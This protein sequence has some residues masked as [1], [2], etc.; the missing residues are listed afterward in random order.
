[1]RIIWSDEAIESVDN[2]ADYI[3]DNFGVN[4]SIEFYDDARLCFRKGAVLQRG[5]SGRR[6]GIATDHLAGV[7]NGLP[8][9]SE[10]RL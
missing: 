9:P 5:Y 3:E 6:R 2:T 7:D 4:R 10:F 8:D 1:M